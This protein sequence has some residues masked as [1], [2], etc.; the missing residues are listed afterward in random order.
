ML[1]IVMSHPVAT[2]PKVNVGDDLIAMLQVPASHSF[3]QPWHMLHKG[4]WH[5][6]FDD[7][8]QSA[9]LQIVCYAQLQWM[10]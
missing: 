6:L 7:G 10:R 1:D 3:P 9:A 5:N 4:Y 8:A 2:M